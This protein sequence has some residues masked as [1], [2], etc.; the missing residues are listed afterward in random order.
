MKAVVISDTHGSLK[1]WMQV[2]PF[3]EDADMIW[4]LGDVLYHG[5]RNPIPEGYN[6]AALAENL[7]RFHIDYV[8]GN[9]DADVDVQ[10]LGLAEMPRVMEETINDLKIVM[11]H[12]DLLPEED[13]VDFAKQHGASI[14][15]RGHT[16]IS[17]IERKGN[18]VIVNP[19][20]LSLPKGGSKNSFATIL[21]D[22]PT[23]I[24]IK[25]LSGKTIIKEVL[26]V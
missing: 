3:L 7:K 1:T 12:G 26:W 15:R 24:E 6:P 25:D 11:I 19:G 16:H 9:C 18:V 14:L 4:H 10:V 21:F 17:R 22:D 13:E 2:L 20:S 23:I 8:R 5:P